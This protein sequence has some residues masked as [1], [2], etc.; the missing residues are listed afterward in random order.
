M[1]CRPDGHFHPQDQQEATVQT[2][3]SGLS[4]GWSLSPAPWDATQTIK[5]FQWAVAR[6]VT[7]VSKIHDVSH[8][9][10]H[11]RV[12]SLRALSYP[13]LRDRSE[14]HVARMITLVSKN[15]MWATHP[16]TG[17]FLR[18]KHCRTSPF[19][20]AQSGMSPGWSL[21]LYYLD[22]ATGDV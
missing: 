9:S 3:F 11:W 8:P 16:A 14:R 21:S 7:L 12:P 19:G 22:D 17:G 10:R 4:P 15:I 1:G 5:Q 6:M 20:I 2:G 18:L 13:T